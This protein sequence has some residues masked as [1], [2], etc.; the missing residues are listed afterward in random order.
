MV[1]VPGQPMRI[2]SPPR[3]ATVGPWHVGY[4]APVTFSVVGV[5][6]TTWN[7][8]LL[9]QSP[10]I[11]ELHATVT[12]LLISDAF[13][14]HG[15]YRSA[16]EA[17][18]PIDSRPITVE[19]RCMVWLREAMWQKRLGYFDAARALAQ[20]VV[21]MPTPTDPGLHGYAN[22][23][24]QRIDYDESPAS[25]AGV[26]WHTVTALPP[27]LGADWRIQ[28]EWHNLRA[29]VTRRRQ[30][31]LQQSADST[32]TPAVLHA[33][34]LRHFESAIYLGLWQRDWDRLQA[35]VANLAFHLQCVY[36]HHFDGAPN[37]QQVFNWHRLTL[38][39]AA[40]LDAARDSAW[41]YIFLGNF[42][43]DHHATLAGIQRVDPLAQEVE[44][45]N[46][47]SETFYQQAIDRLRVCG[48]AR[49]IAIG[50]TQY[51][52]FA[53]HHM[54]GSAQRIALRKATGE[55]LTLLTGQPKT[56]VQELH[57]EGYAAHWPGELLTVLTIHK[58]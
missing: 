44:G 51:L 30:L 26:L 52:R 39:Y 27:V 15:D 34:A 47:A 9:M 21:A 23:F 25:T 55:L 16:I 56:I 24:L 49:Q 53:H 18:K 37:V 35:Y 28:A 19:A 31:T 46:P 12:D 2:A 8:P 54:Q 45:S 42:W 58:R 29:L 13:A 11:D 14:V 33:L 6:S 3:S 7:H 38:A 48:D 41:E 43:L 32:E 17:L 20:R 40:K 10:C 4:Q 1:T 36:G 50:W 5:A 57:A 22:F